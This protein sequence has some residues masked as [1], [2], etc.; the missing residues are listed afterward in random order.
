MTTREIVY[1][2][3]CQQETPCRHVGNINKSADLGPPSV[4]TIQRTNQ[5]TNK[6]PE[7]MNDLLALCHVPR[8]AIIPHIGTQSVAEHT[9]RVAVI[10]LEL[11][12]RLEHAVQAADLIW[13]LVHDGP[14]AWTGDIPG[15]FK[16]PDSD[17]NVAPWWHEYRARVPS[18]VLALV[19]LADMIEGATYLKRH[20]LGAHAAYVAY[21]HY[22]QVTEKAREVSEMVGAGAEHM[23]RIVTELMGD[24]TEDIGRI[25][26]SQRFPNG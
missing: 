14:E 5:V 25:G 24:I 16:S 20:G 18:D 17:K 2:N 9:F 11:C 22:G 13:V 12:L 7:T 19:K 3:V 8:W 21:R 6:D 23:I 1:C 15:P 4:V 26:A 10:Y